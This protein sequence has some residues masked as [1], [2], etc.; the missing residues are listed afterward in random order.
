[1]A[2]AFGEGPSEP[3]GGEDPVSWQTWDDGTGTVVEVVGDADWGKMKLP[4]NPTHEGRSAVYDHGSAVTR[5]Y[6]ITENRYGTG[7]EDAIIQIRGDTSSFS[8]DDNSPVWEDYTV[9]ISRSWQYVQVRAI[10]AA[11]IYYYVDATGGDDGD[12]GL[13]PA[14]AWQTID[15]VNTTVLDVGGGLHVCLK[16]GEHWHEKIL[17]TSSGDV[18]NPI[19]ITDYGTGALPI[20]DGTGVNITVN[21]G[22]IEMRGTS[23]THLHDIRL[24]N[25]RMQYVGQATNS[26]YN[27]VFMSYVDNI[28]ITGCNPDDVVN[29]GILL[30]HC[31]NFEIDNN[32]V[33]NC[34]HATANM[35]ECIAIITSTDGVIYDN[36]VHSADIVAMAGMNIGIN[37]KVGSARIYIHDNHC[38]DL[39]S[40]GVYTDAWTVTT[41]DI[42]IY[43]NTVHDCHYGVACNSEA[44]GLLQ[45]VYMYNNLCYNIGWVGAYISA[46]PGERKDIYI[47]NN[48]LAKATENWFYAIAVETSNL[49]GTILIKNNCCF[50]H[51][52]DL[53]ANTTLGQIV[54]RPLAIPM[55]TASNNIVY[56][57][58]DYQAD[59][60]MPEL[61]NA[62]EETWDDPEFTD[63]AND[64]YN[65]GAASSC[66]NAGTTVGLPIIPSTD[67]LGN[68][69]ICGGTI[70]VG[71][72]EYQE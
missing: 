26:T 3:A 44:G 40:S 24:E 42:Y 43:N 64:D 7:T 5:K 52:A 56:G 12:D 2:K 17:I 14:T 71:C 72:Y 11:E 21:G 70:D 10:T 37:A 15:K 68:T 18:G 13:S 1:M 33:E 47:F 38:H 66:R 32:L 35:D 34:S 59:A 45:R 41:E 65:I 28:R 58:N 23:G 55:I 19:V 57:E 31:T 4:F 48:T 61:D 9:P 69:R 16:R 6:T 30:S 49:S 54:T 62:G 27:A 25:I 22:I 8:Q 51:D 67:Y 50:W 63:W 29:S 46:G 53:G 60:Y 39:I 20:L 36:E